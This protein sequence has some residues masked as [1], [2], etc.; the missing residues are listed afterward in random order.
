MSGEVK[1]VCTCESENGYIF[2]NFFSFL[3]MKGH[4][5]VTFL[6]DKIICPN[7]TTDNLLYVTGYLNGD[8]IDLVWDE[9]IPD[10]SKY[11]SLSLDTTNIKSIFGS[12]KKKDPC[13]VVVYSKTSPDDP[14]PLYFIGMSSGLGGLSRE[15]SKQLSAT[16]TKPDNTSVG[17]EN[18]DSS[19]LIIPVKAFK[20][21]IDSFS[22]CKDPVKLSFHIKDDEMVKHCLSIVSDPVEQ[23]KGNITEKFGDIPNDLKGGVEYRISK[24]KI[25]ILTRLASMHNEGNIRV[26]LPSVKQNVTGEGG[27]AKQDTSLRLLHR[28]GAYGEVG[29]YLSS[30]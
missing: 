12:I 17:F 25:P 30:E 24:D 21:M 22:K 16:L 9:N 13:R 15:G 4:P 28:F 7:R 23:G 20:Q 11:L 27:Y 6:K 29:V 2:K 5:V 19:T 8:E 10:E 26:S 14:V 3:S 18:E 1:V